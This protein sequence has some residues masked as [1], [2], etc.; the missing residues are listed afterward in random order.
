MEPLF[1]TMQWKFHAHTGGPKWPHNMERLTSPNPP[2]ELSPEKEIKFYL[3]QI[4]FLFQVFSHWQLNVAKHCNYA[5]KMKGSLSNYKEN[6]P[7]EPEEG[8]QGQL[9]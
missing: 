4:P 8:L 6:C 3:R 9:P 2:T 7:F 5:G 1:G